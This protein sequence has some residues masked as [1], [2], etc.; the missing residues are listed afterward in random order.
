MYW[1]WAYPVINGLLSLYLCIKGIRKEQNQ[2]IIKVVTIGLFFAKNYS[3][4]TE[5]SSIVGLYPIV[6]KY[7]KNEKPAILIYN[8]DLDQELEF[9]VEQDVYESVEVAANKAYVLSFRYARI[10]TKTLTNL[11]SIDSIPAGYETDE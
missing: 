8:L 5:A 1:I 3:V 11:T 9:S 10:G 2:K 4:N 7:V 6:E